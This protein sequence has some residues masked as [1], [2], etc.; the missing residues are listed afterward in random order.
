MPYADSDFFLALFKPEDWLKGPAENLLRQHK[1]KI[2]TSHLAIL[3]IFMVAKR[4]DLDVENIAG[5]IFEISEV[6][7]V[8]KD[9]ILGAA[10]LIKKEG[11]SVFDAFHSMTCGEDTIISSDSVFDKIGIKRIPLEK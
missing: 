2:W 3:E 7:G 8:S 10:H 1:G 4:L 5:A 9:I 11:V 6:R